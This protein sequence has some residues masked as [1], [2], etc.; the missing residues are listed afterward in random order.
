MLNEK[1]NFDWNIYSM[2]HL[3]KK[4]A[5]PQGFEIHHDKIGVLVIYHQMLLRLRLVQNKGSN[6]L[7]GQTEILFER[8]IETNEIKALSSRG[9]EIYVYIL[10]QKYK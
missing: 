7:L 8:N 6:R 3:M 2:V 4:V 10:K 1:N 5:M 9:I